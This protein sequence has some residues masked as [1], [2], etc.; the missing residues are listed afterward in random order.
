MLASQYK[1]NE[2]INVLNNVMTNWCMA[3]T[4]GTAIGVWLVEHN[5]KRIAIYGMGISGEIL[6]KQLSSNKE[7]NVVC[8]IDR[9]KDIKISGLEMYSIEN[10][11]P[12]VDIV[13]VTAVYSFEQIKADIEMKCKCKVISLDYLVDEMCVKCFD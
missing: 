6:F 3:F 12:Q 11:I 13:V 1:S 8:G 2:R 5:Y 10:E 7:I 4:E 9:N